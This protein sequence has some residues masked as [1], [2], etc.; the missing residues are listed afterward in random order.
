MH[1]SK[2]SK[3]Y[4]EDARIN[5]VL[6]KYCKFLPI[7]VIYGEKSEFIEDPKGEKDEEGNVKK[8][9]KKVPNVLNNTAPAWIKKPADLKAEDYKGFYNELYPFSEDPMF[10]IHSKR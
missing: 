9:E 10:H 4:L 7:N 1:V 3:E 8:I 6:N 5:T 2:D